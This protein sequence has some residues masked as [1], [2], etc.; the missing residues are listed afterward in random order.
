MSFQPFVLEPEDRKHDLG[1]IGVR[2]TVLAA[3]TAIQVQQNKVQSGAEN[4]GP[5]DVQKGV[6]V[7][8][9]HGVEDKP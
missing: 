4:A 1:A 3:E 5:P 8:D 7:L 6:Q 2:I 9:E